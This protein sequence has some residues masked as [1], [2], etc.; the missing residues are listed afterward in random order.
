MYLQSLWHCFKKKEFYNE[1]DLLMTANYG[2]SVS[3]FTLKCVIRACIYTKQTARMLFSL[4]IDCARHFT[5]YAFR[6]TNKSPEPSSK[7]KPNVSAC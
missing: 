3:L 1:V 4:A 6:T 2:A 5:L 7:I